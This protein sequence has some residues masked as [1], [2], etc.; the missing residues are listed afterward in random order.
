[1]RQ[2][3]AGYLPPRIALAYEPSSPLSVREGR[4]V[5]LL[6]RRCDNAPFVAKIDRNAEEL[7]EEFRL[8]SLA[9]EALPGRVPMPVDCFE[10]K[11]AGY[12]LRS[13]LPGKTLD[14]CWNRTGDE[15]ACIELG[16]QACELLEGL[17]AISP[18]LIHRDIKPENLVLG[19]DGQLGL[20]DFDIARRYDRSKDTD[21]HFLG[22]ETTAA[23]EQ[24]GF[25]QTD[26]RTDLYALGRTLIWMLTGSYDQEALDHVSISRRLR[27]VLLRCTDFS[28]ERRYASAGEL[29]AALAGKGP[30][31]LWNA[32]I[33]AV[34]CGVVL[35][36]ALLGP[37]VWNGRTVEFSS[38]CLEAAV[39]QELERPE[40]DITY[41]DLAGVERL[42][43]LGETTFSR[44][45]VY[46][47]M[48][49]SSLD[50]VVFQN[51]SSGDVS[52]LSLLACMP[53]L[54]ELY[55]CSQ[56]ISDISPLKDLPLRV[57]ALTD[58]EIEDLSPL[59]SLTGLER[60]WIGTNPAHDLSPLAALPGLR[61]LNLD[62]GYGTAL[63]DSLTP[64]AG[65]PL[66]IFSLMRVE[67]QDGDW[68]LLSRFSRLNELALC[69]PP[70]EALWELAKHEGLLPVLT[71]FHLNQPDLTVLAGCGVQDLR[72]TRGLERLNG[73]GNLPYLR[74]LGIFSVNVDDLSPLLEVR[75]LETLSFGGLSVEDFSPLNELPRL[76]TVDGD[77]PADVEQDCPGRR[78]VLSRYD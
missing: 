49:N 73:A 24:Y 2:L 55:L 19:E 69:S 20:I 26:R 12:L 51:I 52:D 68:T 10:E 53:N 72:I 15:S 35:C 61:E 22:T 40:G 38:V 62:D 46:T 17:H 36:A 66:E 75:W 50:G 76:H 78:F 77:R 9:Y 14:Q 58:N 37:A 42:A 33:A 8:L 48:L 25:S 28:P 7:M 56:R 16:M 29:R 32:V 54:S 47:C 34:V 44:E 59:S 27:R 30:G 18:P 3:A 21:T 65:L 70:E 6:R 45:Q 5:W 31:P 64:V 4:E 60:L 11:G 63:V 41:A 74:N 57:L 67:V 39:R 13:Y 23:P 71:V 43:L 1:M